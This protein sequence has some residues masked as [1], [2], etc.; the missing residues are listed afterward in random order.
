MSVITSGIKAR[1]HDLEVDNTTV[2]QMFSCAESMGK[3]PVKWNHKTGADAVNGYLDNF[4]LDGN[5]LRADW[6]LLKAHNQYEQALELAERMPSGIGL[7]ASFQGEGE[8]VGGSKKARCKDLVSV[9]LV[10]NPAAN[11]NGLFS[12]AVDSSFNG[13]YENGEMPVG[14][15]Q[16]Q[17]TLGDVI[18]AVASMQEAMEQQNAEIS[19]LRESHDD[20]QEELNGD[21]EG[22]FDHEGGYEQDGYYANE[23]E[24]GHE[25]HEG[26]EGYEGGE[27][28]Y[29]GGGE[30]GAAFNA[31]QGQIV[32]LQNRFEQ[33]DLQAE[34]EVQEH[35]FNV[36]QEKVSK[37]VEFNNELQAENEALKEALST[38]GAQGVSFSAGGGQDIASDWNAALKELQA[39]GM[40]P[41]EAINHLMSSEEGKRLYFEHNQAK[42]MIQL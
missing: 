24:Y 42:G 31:L 28:A 1:G 30:V 8:M 10:A 36:I 34:Q 9:D 12:E 40:K 13:M 22:D 2:A 23:G 33:E 5:Q 4:Y 35:N 19:Q 41:T 39:G 32:E 20:L 15:D 38:S 37:L 17:P 11:P 18:N 3:V 21:H 6:H 14:D 27:A 29:A 25:G 16:G 7:S 26:H